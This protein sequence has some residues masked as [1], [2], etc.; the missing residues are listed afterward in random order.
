MIKKL[1]IYLVSNVENNEFSIESIAVL[2]LINYCELKKDNLNLNLCLN[3]TN[4]INK[5]NFCVKYQNIFE[6]T[7]QTDSNADKKLKICFQNYDDLNENLKN[8][9]LPCLRIIEN[10]KD[11]DG[12]IV[13][14]G[15]ATL[16]RAIVNYIVK[17]KQD[18][19]FK[20]LLVR[21]E[22][23]KSFNLNLYSKNLTKRGT[24]RHV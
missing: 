17:I 5:S 14:S 24:K 20:S 13:Y 4:E 15:L 23:N 3:E 16:Y 10:N 9:S 1:D 2:C 18:K 7:A 22:Q 12:Y 6:F 21:I 11:D 19:R 8:L